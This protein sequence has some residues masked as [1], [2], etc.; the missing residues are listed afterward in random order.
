MG[1]LFVFIRECVTLVLH[2]THTQ[3]LHLTGMALLE[4]HQQLENSEEEATFNFT[5]KISRKRAR[6]HTHIH[7]H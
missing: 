5:L 6:T 4:E 1:C 7:S 2:H 3:V